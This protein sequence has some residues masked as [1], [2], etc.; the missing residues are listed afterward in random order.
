MHVEPKLCVGISLPFARHCVYRE[1]NNK[2]I[3]KASECACV[4]NDY[5]LCAP[6]GK[7]VFRVEMYIIILELRAQNRSL[8][9]AWFGAPFRQIC[10]YISSEFEVLNQ[11]EFPWIWWMVKVISSPSLPHQQLWL[12]STKLSISPSQPRTSN[13]PGW[14]KINLKPAAPQFKN[15]RKH[16]FPNIAALNKEVVN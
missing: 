3:D 2:S 5:V 15:P 12:I 10:V 4:L 13:S 9:M 8:I 14:E 6:P 11:S 1:R 16:F 7:C